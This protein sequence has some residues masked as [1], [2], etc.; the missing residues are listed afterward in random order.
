MEDIIVLYII[1]GILGLGFVVTAVFMGISVFR[2]FKTR[3]VLFQIIGV[4][5]KIKKKRLTNPSHKNKLFG[6]SYVYDEKC[7][8]R[9][10]WNKTIFYFENI[11]NPIIFDRTDKQVKVSSE[12]L[13]NIVEDDFIKKLF[14]PASLASIENILGFITIGLL[15]VMFYFLVLDNIVVKIADDPETIRVIGA[16]CRQALTGGAS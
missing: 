7:E 8:Y 12:A 10:F 1:F 13:N 15:I 6:K 5:G 2:R 16:A 3:S 4:D 11:P 9:D 14:N